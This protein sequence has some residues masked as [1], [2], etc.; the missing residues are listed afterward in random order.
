MK[1]TY[2]ARISF[3]SL[4]ALLLLQS[5]LG[6]KCTNTHT[7][8]AYLPI[9]MSYEDIRA[10]VASG[11]PQALEHPGK[12]YVKGDWLFINE[13]NKGVHVVDNSN[14][15][16]PNVV[17]FITIPGNVD[18]AV[19]GNFLYA[20]SYMDLVTID[21]TDPLSV[22]EV[23]R[24]LAVLPMNATV[25]PDSGVIVDYYEELV[26][27]T[28][29][30][31]LGG[32][33]YYDRVTFESSAAMSMGASAGTPGPPAS[34]DVGGLGGSM[35][36][37]SL[38]G[39]HLYLI[40]MQD[41]HAYNVSNSGQPVFASTQNVGFNI[42]TLWYHNSHLFIG[43][44]NGMYIYA[45]NNAPA[46]PQY[47]S[48]YGHINSCD[49]VVVQGNIAY[50]TLR[51]GTQCQGFTNQLEVIDIQDVTNPT[52]L[53]T[54]PMH[55]PH[56]LGVDD[57]TLFICDNDQGLKAYN[58]NDIATIDQHQVAHLSTIA[59]IDV[60]P[61]FYDDLLIVT[62]PDGIY[63]FDYADPSNLQQ[64]SHLPVVP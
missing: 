8:T 53:H 22:Q 44:Q 26:T 20:D 1:R 37:F 29:D 24:K 60:I 42:E 43:A 9:Y 61:V 12:I 13:L 50:V 21:I 56:G 35:A 18:L 59:A 10:A 28:F 55:N 5:C 4:L 3:L 40:D 19:R 54:Y 25:H 57:S 14:P 51:S 30:C 23:D 39:D 36:R 58:I 47:V 32:G 38:V 52:L 49:P 46:Q 48:F 63:Q 6:D 41:M 31:N 2:F 11:A 62:G 64:L 15:A 17:S 7:Y 16:Q 33:F 45:L 34:F 27:E